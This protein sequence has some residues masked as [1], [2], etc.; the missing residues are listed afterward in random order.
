METKS[1]KRFKYGLEEKLKGLPLLLYGIQ[2]FLVTIPTLIIVGTLVG[3]MQYGDTI[4]QVFYIQKLF[5]L[6][7]VALISQILLGHKLPIVIGPATVLLVGIVSTQSHGFDAIYSSIIIGGVI[8]FIISYTPWLNRLRLLFTPRII[9]VILGLIALTL[10]PT[11]INMSFSGD[12]PEA[13]KYLFFIAFI[14]V[15]LVGNHLLSGIWKSTVLLWGMIMGTLVYRAIS[16]DWSRAM[17]TGDPAE[18]EFI[19]NSF[20]LEPG[21]L[22]SFLCCYIALFINELGSVQAVGQAI[23][24]DNQMLRTVKGLRVTGLSNAVNG[25]FGVIGPVDFSI[26]PGVIMT[27]GCASRYAL[28]PAGVGLIL[29]ALIPDVVI[30]LTSIPDAVMGGVLFYLMC[31]Q[32]GSSLQLVSNGQLIDSFEDA[33]IIAV[34]LMLALYTSFLPQNI[35]ESIPPFIQPIVANGFVVGVI[36]VIL[37]EHLMHRESKS[38]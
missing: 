23:G 1:V 20:V 35:I 12:I 3:G 2:W 34:P 32:L 7:G 27:T 31:M 10:T 30:F 13:T 16:S 6:I 11:I 24:A 18:R 38:K 21:V 9:A 8:L 37:M 22:L 26:S 15:L 25:L 29:C 17:P 33:L 4:G 19:I 5:A 28:I 36:T 14:L